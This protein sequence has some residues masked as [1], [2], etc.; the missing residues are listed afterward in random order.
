MADI[1][2]KTEWV[3]DDKKIKILCEYTITQ[4]AENLTST[5]V[6]DLYMVTD[7]DVNIPAQTHTIEIAESPQYLNAPIVGTGKI[8][9]GQMSKVLRH[10]PNG[11]CNAFSLRFIV[12][13]NAT[14]GGVSYGNLNVWG[15]YHNVD[16]LPAPAQITTD[17]TSCAVGKQLC[18]TI[19]S[20]FTANQTNNY[21]SFDLE[22]VFF[23]ASGYIVQKQY[24]SDNN[25]RIPFELA[26][27][28]PN[29][30]SSICTI[31]CTTYDNTGKLVGYSQCSFT[32]T[33]DEALAPILDY[34][35]VSDLSSEKAV[36]IKSITGVNYIGKALGQYGAT[37]KNVIAKVDGSRCYGNGLNN[38]PWIGDPDST[39]YGFNTAIGNSGNIPVEITCTDSRGF[40]TTVAKTVNVL[41]YC[42][43]QLDSCTVKRCN[44]DG[45]LV[46]EGDNALVE[47]KG[48]VSATLDNTY[49][50]VV[51][52]K[53]TKNT[54]KQ[55]WITTTSEGVN[56]D[57]E[58]NIS[59]ILNNIEAIDSYNFEITV[60]D[61]L[62]QR[63]TTYK[64]LLDSNNVDIDFYGKGTGIAFGGV[65]KEPGIA[66]FY[67]PIKLQ[68]GFV[69]V[70]FKSD[71]FNDFVD[72]GTFVNGNGMYFG[73]MKNCP[74]NDDVCQTI[75][76]VHLTDVLKNKNGTYRRKIIHQTVYRITEDTGIDYRA[77][78]GLQIWIRTGY[79]KV[80]AG[81]DY[82]W[83][84]WRPLIKSGNR[85]LWSG[86][87]H[88]T[89]SHRINLKQKVSE[90]PSGIC[91]VFSQYDVGNK[92]PLDSSWETHYIPKEMVGSNSGV[93]HCVQLVGNCFSI[94]ATK[95]LY[96]TDTLIAG[97]DNN[98]KGG[99]TN[100]I[101]YANDKF[102]LRYV[103]GV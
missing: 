83:D 30:T 88:M 42:D 2:A 101:S 85:I 11:Y 23:N 39:F 31:K 52:Y 47:I 20:P 34:R 56:G 57:Y 99:T 62:S 97:N 91:L 59:S 61:T 102:V 71:D 74:P 53:K 77:S 43:V 55:A 49:K 78:N 94:L 35:V 40:T 64:L 51:K 13:I 41:D 103:I 69:P 7:L 54:D 4:N 18:I 100:G 29:L 14:L 79:Y 26:E 87:Y 24:Y 9:I 92:K 84:E 80:N 8:F 33:V 44:A 15:Y 5:V 86:G 96:I 95:Y 75:L 89:S 25:W 50:V 6:C 12:S 1:S 63:R 93:A 68:K 45:T 82:T 81:D 66:D 38:C 73:Y 28:I 72:E 70:E 37:I 48:R 58:I 27:Q 22:Y 3:S 67:L 65:A 98:I 17:K 46:D 10:K 21:F 90:Q 16:P 36:F 60:N 19:N 76:T 32:L